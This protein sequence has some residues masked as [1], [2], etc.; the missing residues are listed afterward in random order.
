VAKRSADKPAR[1]AVILD[2]SASM[3]LSDSGPSRYQQARQSYDKLKKL[4]EGREGKKAV[5]VDLSV[6]QAAG[7]P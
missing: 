6:W 7:A 4:L 3:I 1:V 5:A 2:D